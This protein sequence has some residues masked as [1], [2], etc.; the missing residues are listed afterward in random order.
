MYI[1][2]DTIL[3]VDTDT[4]TTQVKTLRNDGMMHHDNMCCVIVAAANCGRSTG[5]QYFSSSVAQRRVPLWKHKGKT[6]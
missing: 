4:L 3:P 6:V 1:E 5:D 2:I